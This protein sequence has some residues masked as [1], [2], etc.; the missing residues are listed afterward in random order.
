MHINIK[1]MVALGLALLTFN[2][3]AFYPEGSKEILLKK[4]SD[5]AL[6]ISSLTPSQNRRPCQE[7]LNLAADLMKSVSHFIMADNYEIAVQRL[8]S[9]LGAL[10][11]AELNNCKHYI[12]IAHCKLETLRIKNAIKY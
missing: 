3:N 9:T 5:L 10:Q 8:D 12:H 11:F 4:C 7:K 6:D 1:K 2:V